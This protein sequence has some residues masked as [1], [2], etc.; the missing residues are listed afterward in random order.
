MVLASCH[1]P[2][3]GSSRLD[4]DPATQNN[5]SMVDLQYYV[6]NIICDILKWVPSFIQPSGKKRK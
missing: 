3:L 2:C 4:E 6:R 1:G 5:T